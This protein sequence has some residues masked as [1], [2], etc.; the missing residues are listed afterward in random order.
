LERLPEVSV[1]VDG[2]VGVPDAGRARQDARPVFFALLYINGLDLRQLPLWSR[3]RQLT[4]LLENA[5]DEALLFSSYVEGSEDEARFSEC[6][7][8]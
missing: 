8:R 5:P 1:S 6:L 2:E 3:R 7:L 4:A